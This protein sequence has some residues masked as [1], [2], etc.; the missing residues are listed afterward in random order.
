MFDRRCRGYETVGYRILL[1]ASAVPGWPIDV[2]LP[3]DPEWKSQYAASVGR[4][5]RDGV[6]KPLATLFAHVARQVSSDAERTTDAYR[7]VGELLADLR[8]ALSGSGRSALAENYAQ[9]LKA[10]NP[11][12]RLLTSELRRQGFVPK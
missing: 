4:L 2:P 8:E 3:V 11:R 10:A 9:K 5:L 1:P 6:D 7:R 12:L